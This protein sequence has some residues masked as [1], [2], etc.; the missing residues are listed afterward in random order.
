M[1]NYP[2]LPDVQKLEVCE[3]KI[4]DRILLLVV[5]LLMVGC[6]GTHVPT[7]PLSPV[8]PPSA[9]P[10]VN[11]PALTT[12]ATPVTFS[13]PPVRPWQPGSGAARAVADLAARLGVEPETIDVVRITAD[14]FPAQNLGCPPPGS[15]EPPVQL[16]FVTGQAIVLAV[17]ERQYVYHA[18]GGVVVFC[19]ER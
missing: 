11:T 8:A 13:S 19:G 6:S 3:M 1:W 4:R 7:S 14:D 12:T 2:F 10:P 16:A 15:R 9:T 5:M 17:G 18:H